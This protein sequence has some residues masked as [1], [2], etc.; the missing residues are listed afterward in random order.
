MDDRNPHEDVRVPGHRVVGG[1]LAQKLLSNSAKQATG[2][3]VELYQVVSLGRI[4]PL[5]K[6]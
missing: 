5:K 4:S 2:E 6:Y 3:A 1:Q